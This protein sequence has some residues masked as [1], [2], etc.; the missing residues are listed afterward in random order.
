MMLEDANYLESVFN[1]ALG[2]EDYL[3]TGTAEQVQRWQQ[4]H[5]AVSLTG[6]QKTLL[7]SFVREMK[8]L[9]ISGIW[10]GDCVEQCP[11]LAHLAAASEKIDLRFI[12]RDEVMEL[13]KQL[14]FCSGTRVPVA[15]FMAEDFAFC[16]LYGDR[17]LN[18]YRRL[19]QKQLGAACSTGLFIPDEEEI[20]STTQD[21]LNEH[22]RIQLM[23]RLS[24]RLRK[25][26]Q[27]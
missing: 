23:L 20:A 4:F 2:Y 5:Q 13:A 16:G 17:T 18:R 7:A 9:V 1:Q 22:E 25:K 10:C 6:D 11:I 14:T 19:A 8:V 26:Y 3:A 15:I 21:W 27:D 12:D 24:T